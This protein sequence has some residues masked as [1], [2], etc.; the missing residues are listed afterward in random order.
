[1]LCELAVSEGKN[2]GRGFGLCEVERKKGLE[3]QERYGPL[4]RGKLTSQPISALCLLSVA[5]RR[6]FLLLSSCGVIVAIPCW[7]GPFSA[8]PSPHLPASSYIV[9]DF[10]ARERTLRASRWLMLVAVLFTLVH[11][12]EKACARGSCFVAPL[13][14]V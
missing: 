1:M 9:M 12:G 11:S 3:L 14:S 7:F 8:L 2:K 5:E 10:G 13:H 4:A 6:A